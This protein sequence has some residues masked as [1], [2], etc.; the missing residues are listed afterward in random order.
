MYL[1]KHIAHGLGKVTIIYLKKQKYHNNNSLTMKKNQLCQANQIITITLV[2]KQQ[3]HNHKNSFTMRTQLCE[4][5]HI[6][7]GSDQH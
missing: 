7:I 6:V 3:Q 5:N 1:D 4:E 2:K